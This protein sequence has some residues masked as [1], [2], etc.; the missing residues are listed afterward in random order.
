MKHTFK[1]WFEV[2]RYWSFV[3]SA[4]PVIAGFAYL[5]CTRQVPSGPV[6]IVCF[7]LS[8]LGIVIFHAAGNV[9]SD[10][11]D[12][13]KGVDNEKAFSVPNLVF[14]KFEPREYL[15][16]SIGLFAVGIAVGLAIVLMSGTGV[17]VVG[18]IGFVLTALYAFFKFRALGDLDIFIVFGVLPML[19]IS[20]AV[21]G[22][23]C[24]DILLLSFPIGIITVSV[25]HANNTR[26]TDSDRESGIRTFAMLIGGKASAI[27]YIV[28]MI[29]PFAYVVAVVT[30]GALTPFALLSLRALA[31]AV[32][33]IKTA[34]QYNVKGIAAL[35]GLD[36]ASAQMQLVFSALLS[37][38]LFAGMLV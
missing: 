37:L 22:H 11:F 28:Y 29:A 10:Y 20:C 9:L 4:M 24:P 34:A 30:A 17:L 26:D 33:N 25:L 3:V 15:A 38:G 32:K 23:V 5:C 6:P 19:G 1:E 7:V 31:P 2:T 18:V 36:Q 13:R 16:F 35:E 14:H 27:L 12:Y 21:T 8:V